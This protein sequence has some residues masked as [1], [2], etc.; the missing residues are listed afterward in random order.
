MTVV[1]VVSI[2]S[3]FWHEPFTPV[4]L[5]VTPTPSIPLTMRL[6]ICGRAGVWSIIT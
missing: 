5:K 6:E 4:S 3:I 1:R 2:V